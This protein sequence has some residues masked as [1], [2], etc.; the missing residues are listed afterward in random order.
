MADTDR[1]PEARHRVV[2]I[3]SGFGGLFAAKALRR[4]DV[5]VTVVSKT[6]Y[7]LFQPLLYQVAT[8]ILSE[9]EVAPATREV[10]RRQRN[11]TVLLGEV[12]AVD[13]AARTVTFTT[14]ALTKTI[15]Y[16][17][18]IVTAGAGQ[19]YF[20]NEAFAAYAPGMKSIDD[21]LELR[22]R[23]F[24]AFEIAELQDDP[25]S[26]AEWMTFA[27]VGAGAT[28]VEMAGQIA[29]LARGTLRRD[30]RRIDPTK[31]RVIVIDAQPAVLPGFAEKLQRAAAR[32]LTRMGVELRLGVKVVGMDAGSVEVEEADGTRHRIPT[33]CKVWAAGVAASPLGR[34]LAEQAGAETDRAGRVKINPDLT[35]PGHP[36]VFLVGD[37]VTLD[38]LPGV[39]QVAMQ[40]GTYAARTVVRRL[41]G[42]DTS[43]PFHY[44]DKGSLATVSRFHAVADIKG[45]KLTG[46]LAW[47]VWLAVHIFYLIGFKNRVTTLFH[48]AITF[49]SRGRSERTA[50]EQQA[51]ARGA[52]QE[53]AARD[54]G[55]RG[56]G[57]PGSA[58]ADTGA[59]PAARPTSGT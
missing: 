7:H 20:G 28:G 6:A 3:G 54:G 4:A 51:F 55:R 18:L 32:R 21:A 35:L 11:T 56:P 10:L 5:D 40:G 27:V 50:T 37:L 38:H 34:Q 19:S 47:V 12:T 41:K 59:Q 14:P 25:A 57:S 23:I 42:Q 46:F 30:Y 36:E 8:G 53:L 48:W 31:A 29:E 1:S 44:F 13:L 45:L 33:W 2:I 9:G 24:G 26:A 43:K 15:G 49:V 39:A 22:A 16:D 17:S 52:M 58:A